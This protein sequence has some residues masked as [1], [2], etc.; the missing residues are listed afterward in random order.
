MGPSLDSVAL[1][2]LGLLLCLGSGL[3]TGL[4]PGLGLVLGLGTGLGPGL[5]LCLFIGVRGASTARVIL[6]P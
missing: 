3:G 5:G 4:G 1:I 6:R 2:G